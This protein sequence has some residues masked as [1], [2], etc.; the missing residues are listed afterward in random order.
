MPSFG[1]RDDSPPGVWWKPWRV[2]RVH[3]RANDLS[4]KNSWAWPK[5]WSSKKQSLRIVFAIFRRQQSSTKNINLDFSL[6]QLRW[7]PL[8]WL[9]VFQNETQG[10]RLGF[11]SLQYWDFLPLPSE[12]V[13]PVGVR[14]YLDVITKL[15]RIHRFPIFFSYEAL[16]AREGSAIIAKVQINTPYTLT[17]QTFHA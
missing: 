2:H 7:L 11:P 17:R 12:S 4:K 5:A 13:R 9:I 15:S 16:L 6:E 1:E 8:K 10:T 3:R 14:W